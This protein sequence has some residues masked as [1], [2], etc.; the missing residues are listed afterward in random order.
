MDISKKGSGGTRSGQI[1]TARTSKTANVNKMGATGVYG[2]HPSPALSNYHQS[3]GKD[4]IPTKFAES[5][6]GTSN[7]GAN[8]MRGPDRKTKGMKAKEPTTSTVMK[9]PNRYRSPM[10]SK[11]QKTRKPGKF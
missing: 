3:M 4:T 2:A 5:G 7:M 9:T 8:K 6:I 11:A 10:A 1:R